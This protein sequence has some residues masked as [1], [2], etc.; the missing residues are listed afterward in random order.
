MSTENSVSGTR[1]IITTSKIILFILNFFALFMQKETLVEM[2]TYNEI[3]VSQSFVDLLKEFTK[4][5]IRQQ[6]VDLLVWS[7]EYF[8]VRVSS[9]TNADDR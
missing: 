4:N 3:N 7:E 8:R 2:P 6:P 1:K 9:T 5:V